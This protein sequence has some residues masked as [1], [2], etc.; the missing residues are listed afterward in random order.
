MFR[1]EDRIRSSLVNYMPEINH[2]AAEWLRKFTCR[3]GVVGMGRGGEH[4]FFFNAERFIVTGKSC[5][6]GGL[7]TPTVHVHVSCLVPTVAPPSLFRLARPTQAASASKNPLLTLLNHSRV[8][9]YM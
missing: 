3:F 8:T 2:V 1:A 6:G 5:V 9:S 4:K 7:D